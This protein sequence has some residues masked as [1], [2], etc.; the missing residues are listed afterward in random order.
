MDIL[1]ILNERRIGDFP[2]VV[3][4][5]IFG[6]PEPPIKLKRK[7]IIRTTKSA[8]CTDVTQT[9][10]QSSPSQN[11]FC[12]G[13]TSDASNM[14]GTDIIDCGSLDHDRDY[15]DLKNMANQPCQLL[16]PHSFVYKKG[17]SDRLFM[18]PSP[19]TS[20]SELT[21][22]DYE[23]NAPLED[24]NLLQGYDLLTALDTESSSDSVRP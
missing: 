11:K 8:G 17:L 24:S 7:E 3:T 18:E 23:V 6:D 1:S 14:R 9:L 13:N 21:R 16:I 20:L 15:S 5:I 10:R 4:S 19:M 22:Q 2:K 12:F